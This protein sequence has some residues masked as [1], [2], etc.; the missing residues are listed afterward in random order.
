MNRAETF[1][2]KLP[3]DVKRRL[4]EV[5]ELLRVRKN[6]VVE[7]AIREELDARIDASDR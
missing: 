7:H 3:R 4:D 5:C 1:A 6:F 2:T